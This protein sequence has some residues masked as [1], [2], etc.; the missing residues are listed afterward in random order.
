MNK[1]TWIFLF[2][3]MRVLSAYA[4]TP[5]STDYVAEKIAILQAEINEITNAA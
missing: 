1:R 5:A 4:S 2:F 3:L